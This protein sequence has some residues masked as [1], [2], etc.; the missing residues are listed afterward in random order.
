M[1]LY[2]K[3][4]MS[5]VIAPDKP[6]LY[7]PLDGHCALAYVYNSTSSN[8]SSLF[9]VYIVLIFDIFIPSLYNFHQKFCISLLNLQVSGYTGEIPL[10]LA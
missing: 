2:N 3:Q 5:N 8:S 6:S 7:L 1:K 4:S 9:S 10:Q